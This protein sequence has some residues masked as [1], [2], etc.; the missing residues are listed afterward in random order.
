[1]QPLRITLGPKARRWAIF[2]IVDTTDQLKQIVDYWH[3]VT[4]AQAATD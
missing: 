3:A 4:G 2:L 1:M